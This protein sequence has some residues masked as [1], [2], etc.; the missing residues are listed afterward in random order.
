M[1]T[2]DL[3]ISPEELREEV[4]ERAATKLAKH[5]NRSESAME[6][7]R[8]IITNVVSEVAHKVADD[9]IRPWVE[10]QIESVVLQ[11]TN[12]WGEARGK[13]FTFRE[14]LIDRAEKYL[15]EEVDYHGKSRAESRDS[16]FRATGTRIAY[17][18]DKHLYV[19]IE[20]AMKEALATANSA[21]VDGIQQ[22]VKM[23]LAEIG[24]ALKVTTT[25]KAR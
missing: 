10:G 12:E 2:L 23:K 21:I 1:S 7:I 15:M 14:Y 17:M 19:T 4:I 6:P 24:T 9:E 22:T 13:A 16:Y 3:G 11:Q 25:T 18:I 8:D 20:D 5:I